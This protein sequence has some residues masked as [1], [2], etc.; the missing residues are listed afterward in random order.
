MQLIVAAPS[1]ASLPPS[2][3]LLRPGIN[4]L[5]INPRVLVYISNNPLKIG[6]SC[7]FPPCPRC[8]AVFL[9]QPV[10]FPAAP[11]FFLGQVRSA[12]AFPEGINAG[13]IKGK[14]LR[15]L[16]R[17]CYGLGAPDVAP[18]VARR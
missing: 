3:P 2:L 11:P 6:L 7:H 1:S 17:V 9:F 13:R 5:I 15:I 12:V 18:G 14:C 16:L 4:Y 8:C 10:S